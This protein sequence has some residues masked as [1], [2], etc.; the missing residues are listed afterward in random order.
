MAADAK[1]PRRILVVDDEWLLA[2][3]LAEALEDVGYLVQ[4]ASDGQ[5]ALDHVSSFRPDLVITD[6]M[7]PRLTG[8]ELATAVRALSE[9]GKTPIILVSG[10]QGA[11]GRERPDLFQAVLE[12]PYEIGA[13]LD[14]VSLLCPD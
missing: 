8:L 11:I 14:Q 3:W 12:K 4:T 10:A 1:N 13:L 7:M 6:F 9:L 2:T 5:E